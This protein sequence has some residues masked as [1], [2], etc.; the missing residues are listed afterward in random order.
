MEHLAV[1]ETDISP[2]TQEER[3]LGFIVVMRAY[4]NVAFVSDGKANGPAVT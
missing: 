3:E 4:D 2:R 1:N